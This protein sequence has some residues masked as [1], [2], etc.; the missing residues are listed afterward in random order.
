MHVKITYDEFPE[1]PTAWGTFGICVGNRRLANYATAEQAK[2]IIKDKRTWVL[3][4]YEHG[5]VHFSFSGEGMQ[6]P[7]DTACG[8]A[9]LYIE[10]DLIPEEQVE[11]AARS[12][13]DAYNAW[14]NGWVYHA[15]ILENGEHVDSCGGFYLAEDIAD[16]L[17]SEGYP[18][19]SVEG[20][21]TEE[22]I[23]QGLLDLE[24]QVSQ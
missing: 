20:L 12:W 15:E 17:R 11:S 8:G 3:D 14:A 10:N 22:E 18:V 19:T 1:C 5:E 6:C 4:V 9:V 21:F 2:E 13:L 7:W 24:T 16:F 23:Q